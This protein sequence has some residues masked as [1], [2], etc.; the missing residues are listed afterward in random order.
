MKSVKYL[1]VKRLGRNF[2]ATNS[3]TYKKIPCV[4]DSVHPRL[5]S[6]VVVTLVQVIHNDTT[7]PARNAMINGLVHTLLHRAAKLFANALGEEYTIGGRSDTSG[8]SEIEWPL[9]LVFSLRSSSNIS[10]RCTD[11]FEHNLVEVR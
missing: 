4:V 2:N 9:S 7:C 1:S 6:S 10:T 8:A 11:I 5:T 3:K